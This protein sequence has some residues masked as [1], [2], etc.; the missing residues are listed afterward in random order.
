[1]RKRFADKTNKTTVSITLLSMGLSP[2]N[3]ILLNEVGVSHK[4]RGVSVPFDNI[5]HSTPVTTSDET[6]RV[7]V[8]FNFF[9]PV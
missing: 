7:F 1:M 6:R 2:P 5:P 3:L 9:M 4:L 8:A